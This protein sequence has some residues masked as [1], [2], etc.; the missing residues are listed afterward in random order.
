M[1]IW[2]P[3]PL[4]TEGLRTLAPKKLSFSIMVGLYKPHQKAKG[5]LLGYSDDSEP[6]GGSTFRIPEEVAREGSLG[7]R[8]EGPE[9]L[10]TKFGLCMVDEVA[11]LSAGKLE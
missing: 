1:L 11:A 9:G 2:H 5:Y 10:T 7:C 4:T 3:F 8:N 6:V